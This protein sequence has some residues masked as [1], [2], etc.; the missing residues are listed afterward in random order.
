MHELN[1]SVTSAARAHAIHSQISQMGMSNPVFATDA[2]TSIDTQYLDH[3]QSEVV[4]KE[5][6]ARSVHLNLTGGDTLKTTTTTIIMNQ[7]DDDDDTA[8]IRRAR[9]ARHQSTLVSQEIDLLIC[10]N[11]FTIKTRTYLNF[12][13]SLQM[14]KPFGVLL[15]L[16]LILIFLFRVDAFVSSNEPLNPDENI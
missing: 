8:A 14:L 7:E 5:I 16:T 11:V 3:E 6:E 15:V 12:K 9:F 2:M 10:D 4:A 1:N 13:K